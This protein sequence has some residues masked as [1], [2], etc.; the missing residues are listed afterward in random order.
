MA[1]RWVQGAAWVPSKAELGV[2]ARGAFQALAG[3]K[4]P[5]AAAPPQPPAGGAAAM[6]AQARRCRRCG[7]HGRG[8]RL[9]AGGERYTAWT[10]G[11]LPELLEIRKGPARP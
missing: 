4:A 9:M 1:A 2:Q 8:N 6:E 3:L 7:T 5:A 11:E 10:F